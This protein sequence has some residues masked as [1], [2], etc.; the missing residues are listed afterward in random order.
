MFIK[1]LINVSALKLR[2]DTWF[3]VSAHLP[4]LQS[5]RPHVSLVQLGSFHLVSARI[6]I[7]YVSCEAVISTVT[8][9]GVI[10]R[11]LTL[12]D[13]PKW[14]RKRNLREKGR[15]SKD[16]DGS[17]SEDSVMALSQ[18]LIFS[19]PPFTHHGLRFSAPYKSPSLNGN[20]MLLW[21][22]P[23]EHVK[24]LLVKTEVIWY[25]FLA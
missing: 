21:T 3:L 20:L 4:S 24:L 22:S 7:G 19:S 23:Q 6:F 12:A 15:M 5:P 11:G 14:K 17:R 18:C 13:A 10:I 8:N 25:T 2:N 1:K 16:T 9:D